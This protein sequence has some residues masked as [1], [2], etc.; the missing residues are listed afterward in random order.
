MSV[1]IDINEIRARFQ[2]DEDGVYMAIPLLCDRI[3][4]LSEQRD[5]LCCDLASMRIHLDGAVSRLAA[6]EAVCAEACHNGNHI[7]GVSV[8]SIPK[9]RHALRGDAS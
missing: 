4:T 5:I 6:V 7:D 1:P 8:V 9:V 2:A 3:D